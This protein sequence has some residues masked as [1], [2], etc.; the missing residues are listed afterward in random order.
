MHG[1]MGRCAWADGK[2]SS[3]GGVP[4][5]LV[6]VEGTPEEQLLVGL[7]CVG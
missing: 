1:G 6:A 2:A 5:E 7:V 4:E 3:S